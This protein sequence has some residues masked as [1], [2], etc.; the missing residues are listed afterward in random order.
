MDPNP[1]AMSDG[2]GTL[3]QWRMS[4]VGPP[5]IIGTITH[6]EEIRSMTADILF[7]TIL[8]AAEICC[9]GDTTPIALGNKLCTSVF[10]PPQSADYQKKAHVAVS[11]ESMSAAIRRK[12]G[13]EPKHGI[14]GVYA[15]GCVRALRL[16]A[17]DRSSYDRACFSAV[18]MKKGKIPHCGGPIT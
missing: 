10:S 17:G 5:Q 14:G 13:G 8:I 12:R 9:A 7:I 11:G 1:R 15:R 18:K 6:A 2:F 4:H 3:P 16:T